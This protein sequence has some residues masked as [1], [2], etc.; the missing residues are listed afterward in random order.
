M[1]LKYFKNLEEKEMKK[2]NEYIEPTLEFTCF[3]E[4]DV[5]TTSPGPNGDPIELPEDTFK[6][7]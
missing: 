2:K 4:W 3:G 6:D 7:F 1:C 5:V